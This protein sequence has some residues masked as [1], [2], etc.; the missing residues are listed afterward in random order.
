MGGNTM[1]TSD[2]T[3]SNIATTLDENNRWRDLKKSVINKIPFTESGQVIYWDIK[4]PGF[5]LL[6]GKR[7]KSFI[8]Q[9]DVPD[10]LT[11]KGFKTVKRTIGRFGTI[12]VEQARQILVGYTDA[13]GNHV[14][15]IRLTIKSSI[16]NPGEDITLKEMIG[17][18]F[19]DKKPKRGD[20]HKDITVSDYTNTMERKFKDLLPLTLPQIASLD[21]DKIIDRYNKMATKNGNEGGPYAARNA[22][23]IL[24]AILNYAAIK[25]PK[26][27]KN[28]PFKVIAASNIQSEIKVRTDCLRGDDF[29]TF[30]DK[31]SGFNEITRDAYLFCLYHG[32]RPTAET[33]SLR[34]EWIDLNQ[35]IMSIPD[36]KNRLPLV[37]PLSRQ[38]FQILNRCQARKIDS[39][40]V[41]PSVREDINK[42]GH[43]RLQAQALKYRTGLDLTVQGLRRTFITVARSLRLYHEADKL[44]NHLPMNKTEGE[45]L[46]N[47]QRH[48]HST[49]RLTNQITG[50]TVSDT[51]Y[52]QQEIEWLREPLQRITDEIDKQMGL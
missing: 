44:T 48:K 25:W 18:Y 19:K 50:N 12:T 15:S 32:L 38:S 30:Y 35:Q 40:F 51:H 10:P 33:A 43:V 37:V 49:R 52:D 6:V 31:I 7:S 27:I 11:K 41:F 28:N 16:A 46:D 34:W 4:E 39:P 9:M 2:T 17:I 20:K 47:M 45:I 8:V 36:T 24:N 42:T 22:F 5:G 13:S 29:K 1:T 14:P 21:P 26:A 3:T 23:T